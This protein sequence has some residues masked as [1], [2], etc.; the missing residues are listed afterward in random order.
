MT[1]AARWC[2]GTVRVRDSCQ[3]V[4]QSPLIRPPGDG[5]DPTR[6]PGA[7]G[8]TRRPAGAPRDRCRSR[9]SLAPSFCWW[10]LAGL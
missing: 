5:R 3:S 10:G 8:V 1:R 7:R 6:A 9:V 4:G 2:G